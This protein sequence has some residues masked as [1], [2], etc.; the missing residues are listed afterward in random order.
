MQS[1]SCSHRALHPGKPPFFLHEAGP[2]FN[3]TTVVNLSLL[4]VAAV[5]VV[6]RF[7]IVLLLVLGHDAGEHLVVLKHKEVEIHILV[8]LCEST[9]D[10]IHHHLE[11]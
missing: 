8:V 3:V 1:P 5:D 6:H 2:S 4:I 11:V 9:L 7:V 10:G